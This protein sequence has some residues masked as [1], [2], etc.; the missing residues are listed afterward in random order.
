M[1]SAQ[2]L[3]KG[4]ASAR[5]DPDRITVERDRTYTKIPLA[6]V[7]EARPDGATA[8][9][10]VLTDGVVHR[11]EGPNPTA[12]AAFLGALDAALPEERDP[13]G[14]ASVV[15]EP[16]GVPLKMRYVTGALAALVLPW[17]GW[18]V[19]AGSREPGSWFFVF[20][21]GLPL[22]LGLLGTFALLTSLYDRLVLARRGITV[23]A[24]RAYGADGRALG[25]HA[26]TDAAGAPHHHYS[27]R[28]GE[29]LLVVYDPQRPGRK[30]AR[31][32]WVLVALQFLAGAVCALGCL[33][34]GLAGALFPFL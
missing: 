31:Q 21:S 7:R 16:A 25:H 23:R 22:L 29:T 3:V 20:V 32:W 12:T 13:A 9:E 24:V 18:T 27:G 4:Y 10:V 17:T 15:T 8:I 5:L 11:L 30:V 33:A 6:A 28:K 34:L 14:S 1:A 19:W 26:Y 2:V